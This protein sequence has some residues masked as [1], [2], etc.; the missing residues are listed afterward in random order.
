M[1]SIQYRMHPSISKFTNEKFYDGK[2]IDG[3]NIKDYNNIYLHSHM[4]GAYS[5]I[6]VEEGF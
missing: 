4:Y 1:L 3:P 6:H 5:F 2:I